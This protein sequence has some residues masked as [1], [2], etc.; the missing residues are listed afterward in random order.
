M[1]SRS[2]QALEAPST[3]VTMK[4]LVIAGALFPARIG[5]SYRYIS[6]L[7]DYLRSEGHD[8]RALVAKDII[9]TDDQTVPLLYGK[10]RRWNRFLGIIGDVGVI[11]RARR[12]HEYDLV[13]SHHTFEAFST[14]VAL[15]F[16]PVRIVTIFHENYY[17]EWRANN[18]GK[19]SKG[20]ECVLGW[21]EKIA[22]KSTRVTSVALSNYTQQLLHS[23]TVVVPPWISVQNDPER[24]LRI[25]RRIITV[26][27]L[28]PRMGLDGLI[29]VISLLRHQFSGL[30]LDILGTGSMENSLRELV[31]REHLE[32]VVSLVGVVNDHTRDQYLKSADIFVIPSLAAEGFGIAALEALASGLPVVASRLGGLLEVGLPSE[33]MFTPGDAEDMARALREVLTMSSAEYSSL[34]RRAQN[35]A[36]L[37]SRDRFA[38]NWNKILHGEIPDR[39]QVNP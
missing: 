24:P 18:S 2:R 28:E 33:L 1:Y 13:I 29:R 19:A 14:V 22:Y 7:V 4:V 11:S 16:S 35:L 32:Q 10:D 20:Y 3:E 25:P 12:A 37:Y 38:H 31:A 34:R 21:M 23:P 6:M 5:G 8:V 30:H 39:Q 26:R 9:T 36:R 17:T 15:W 27:R